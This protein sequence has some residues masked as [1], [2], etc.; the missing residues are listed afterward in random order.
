MEDS[1]IEYPYGKSDPAFLEIIFFES[2]YEMI[3]FCIIRIC[4]VPVVTKFSKCSDFQNVGI[5]TN[6]LL[7]DSVFSLIN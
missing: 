2:T 4:S 7:N 1:M 5:C 3:A 6:M